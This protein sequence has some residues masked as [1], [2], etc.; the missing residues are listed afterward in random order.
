MHDRCQYAAVVCLWKVGRSTNRFSVDDQVL[1]WARSQSFP[2][3]LLPFI[4]PTSLLSVMVMFELN[5]PSSVAFFWKGTGVEL[6]GGYKPATWSRHH[7]GK[8]VIL[9]LA[10]KFSTFYG[11]RRLI[12]VFTGSR[13]VSVSR[14]KSVLPTHPYS[15]S[16]R[17]ILMLSSHLP[18]GSKRHKLRIVGLKKRCS[19]PRYVF[20]FVMQRRI[21]DFKAPEIPRPFS[22]GNIVRK[23]DLQNKPKSNVTCNM[24]VSV[25]P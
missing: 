5:E 1:R 23:S 19:R 14:A 2:R 11:T 22:F 4:R 21:L 9:Q 13:H 16:R 10:E 7:F 17:S 15:V 12:V 3:D 24:S 8:P 6:R 25:Q 18:C 20:F